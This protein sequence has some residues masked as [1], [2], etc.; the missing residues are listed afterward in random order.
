[1][2]WDTHT[3]ATPCWRRS[4]ASHASTRAILA[5]SR[6]AAGSS[7]RRTR[8]R[9]SAAPTTPGADA[10]RRISAPPSTPGP[11]RAGPGLPSAPKR[12]VP[13]NGRRRNPPTNG[14]PRAPAAPADASRWGHSLPGPPHPA[15]HCRYEGRDQPGPGQAGLARPRGTGKAQALPGFQGE[16]APAT[17]PQSRSSTRSSSMARYYSKVGA[18]RNALQRLG[19]KQ[20]ACISDWQRVVRHAGGTP[21]SGKAF[22]TEDTE[23]RRGQGH[24]LCFSVCSAPLW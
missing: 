9:R 3:S 13:G 24:H 23:L 4:C 16:I 10:R 22:T 12:A 6:F 19:E 21:L 2:S 18:R 14:S 8:G 20:K 11:R 5:L 1:M 7:S 17:L 15:E